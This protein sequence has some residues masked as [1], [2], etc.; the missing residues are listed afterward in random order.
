MTALVVVVVL[1]AL[2]VVAD[3]VAAHT[4]AG[5][6][7][8]K[9]ESTGR[10]RGTPEVDVRGFPFLTQA[11][12]GLY[13]DIAVTAAGVQAGKV[14]VTTFDAQLRGV[15]LPLS[16]A[17]KGSVRSVPVDTISARAEVSWGELSNLV[18]DR[19]LTVSSAG[20]GLARVT[21][22]VTVLGRSYHA[23]AVSRPALDGRTI[24]V[25]AT[26]FEV[27]SGAAD[28][29]LSKALGNRL[30]FRV[31]LGALPYGLELDGLGADDTGVVLTA[32]ARD[33]VLQ[34]AGGR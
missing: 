27:G 19:G 10:L 20:S 6:V 28:A 12:G 16:S 29:V 32:H 15:H 4:A 1:V 8:R 9:L 34:A 22:T 21:G 25:T 2:V 26:R 7:A 14:E 23:S 3:R 24:V 5:V 30:D 13:R 11:V 31:E 33:V 18:A 17:L